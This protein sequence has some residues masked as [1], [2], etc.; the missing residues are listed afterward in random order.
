MEKNQKQSGAGTEAIT[1]INGLQLDQIEMALNKSE[2]D[3]VTDAVLFADEVLGILA[4]L[5]S[6]EML[7][8]AY[9]LS[10]STVMIVDEAR[11]RLDRARAFTDPIE[12]E[13][14]RAGKEV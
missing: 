12:L 5:I 8:S 3:A 9:G 10:M 6:D 4:A 11:K 13:E 7:D 1:S 2:T 14:I